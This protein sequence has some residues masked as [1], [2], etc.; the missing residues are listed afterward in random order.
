MGGLLLVVVLAVSG[1]Y[2]L[3]RKRTMRASVVRDSAMSKGKDHVPPG[4]QRFSL[5]P[6]EG[7][8]ID[9]AQPTVIGRTELGPLVDPAKSHS[10]S[11][12]HF[13][14]TYKNGLPYITDG[15]DE[16]HSSNGTYI[17]KEPLGAKHPKPLKDGDIIG[18]ANL[19]DLRVAFR[20]IPD[21]TE[22][23]QE[24]T[25]AIHSS[26]Q[27][28]ISLPSGKEIKLT[29]PAILGR[30]ILRSELPEDI[31]KK[32]SSRHLTLR[33][34][35]GRVEIMDGAEGRPSKNGVWVNDVKLPPDK[36]MSIQNADTISL[37]RFIDIKIN[38]K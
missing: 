9:V 4:Q 33:S 26:Q 5:I 8:A 28:R 30:E 6:P 3:G 25:N 32:I 24:K 20:S 7:E 23:A 12:G 13:Q 15:T 17:N 14:I 1:A 38:I 16:T 22:V 29:L 35:D 37:G 11:R 18:V 36:S 2:L 27:V 31:Q 10:I 19:I 21:K 34:I